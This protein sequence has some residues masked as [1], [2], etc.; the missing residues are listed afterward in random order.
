MTIAFFIGGIWVANSYAGVSS[1]VARALYAAFF[2]TF[3]VIVLVAVTT[4]GWKKFGDS[5]AQ[6]EVGQKC[7]AYL[8][9]SNFV[10]AV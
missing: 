4:L 3:V 7:I 8:E 9:S 6:G 5:V 1:H 10:K 2:V